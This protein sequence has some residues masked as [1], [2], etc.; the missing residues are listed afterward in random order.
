MSQAVIN[1][2][3]SSQGRWHQP[4][5]TACHTSLWTQTGV[6]LAGTSAPL[7]GGSHGQD[8]D[9]QVWQIL[10]KLTPLQHVSTVRA[11]NRRAAL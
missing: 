5:S 6:F 9:Q 3:A 11:L 10:V 8:W 7:K 1:P 2:G 4:C